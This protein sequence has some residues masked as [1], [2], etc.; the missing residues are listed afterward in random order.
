MFEGAVE[1][2][3]ELLDANDEEPGAAPGTA[4]AMLGVNGDERAG[5]EPK[6]APCTMPLLDVFGCCRGEPVEQ[7]R[8]TSPAG[9]WALLRD[10]PLAEA[11][12]RLLL[13]LRVRTISSR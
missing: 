8:S 13:L 1:A 5:E 2:A 3:T 4:T 9:V 11:L 6:A 7:A 12:G 10:G